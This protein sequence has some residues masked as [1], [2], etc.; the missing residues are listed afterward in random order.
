MTDVQSD[1]RRFPRVE[2]SFHVDVWVDGAE[3][4][5]NGRLVVLGGG[6]A[7]LELD[8]RYPISSSLRLRFALATLGEI[9][10]RAMVRYVIE[11]KGVAVEFLDMD[12]GERDRIMVFVEA[13]QPS[14][15]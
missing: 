4:R 8:D 9:G 6:G 3:A 5:V 15:S 1:R 14:R 11:G 10:C 12:P 2:V 13:R 7:F